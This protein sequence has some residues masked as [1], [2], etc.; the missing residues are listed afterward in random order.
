MGYDL[1]IKYRYEFLQVWV[2]SCLKGE[3]SMCGLCGI[4][5][6]DNSNDLHMYDDISGEYV[7]LS[8]T[9]DNGNAKL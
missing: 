3:L 9:W 6:G 4:Y 7:Y 8:N 5:D 1:K 2:S